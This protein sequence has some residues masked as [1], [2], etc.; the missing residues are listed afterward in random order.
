MIDI[1]STRQKYR[2]GY[3]NNWNIR[4]TLKRRWYFFDHHFL[5][6]EG[7]ERKDAIEFYIRLSYL[8]DE[9]RNVLKDAFYT[10]EG[11]NKTTDQIRSI[12]KKMSI[13]KNKMPNSDTE[14]QVFNELFEGS[15]DRLAKL[16]D[17]QLGVLKRLCYGESF[18]E[19]AL[20]TTEKMTI[21]EY[22]AVLKSI[23][24]TLIE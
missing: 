23:F 1:E 14:L 12:L 10:K 16:D 2:Q 18:F 20:A 13:H 22:R 24:V 4:N 11:S 8:T 9:E 7:Y 19:E 6:L 17:I 3:W 21:N 15:E 5:E